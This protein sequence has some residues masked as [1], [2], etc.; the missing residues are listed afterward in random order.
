MLAVKWVGG[1]RCGGE[2]K[3]EASGGEEWN[4]GGRL[5]VAKDIGGDSGGWWWVVVVFGGERRRRQAVEVETVLAT[6]GRGYSL[7][8]KTLRE[9]TIDVGNETVLCFFV[10][11]L[12]CS[13]TVLLSSQLSIYFCL[14]FCLSGRL[15]VCLSVIRFATTFFSLSIFSAVYLPMYIILSVKVF[16]RMPVCLS[17]L[18]LFFSLFLCFSSAIHSVYKHDPVRFVCLHAWLSFHPPLHLLLLQQSPAL[19]RRNWLAADMRGNNETEAAQ[20]KRGLSLL[21]RN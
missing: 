20:K 1:E 17:T 2:E 12:S 14:W 5:L 10:I 7:L 11:I 9:C 21:F 13:F 4:W 3:M 18:Y 19:Q 16:L 8:V 6:R 15:S